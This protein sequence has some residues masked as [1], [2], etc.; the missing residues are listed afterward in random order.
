MGLPNILVHVQC[1]EFPVSPHKLLLP[2]ARNDF[3]EH[4]GRDHYSLTL[5]LYHVPGHDVAIR[6]ITVPP[7]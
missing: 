5:E 7:L 4:G 6:T 2:S 1:Y 3:L